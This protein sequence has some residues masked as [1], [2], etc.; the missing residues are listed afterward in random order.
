MAASP[1]TVNPSYVYWLKRTRLVQLSRFVS[2][3]LPFPAGR[4]YNVWAWMVYFLFIDLF[5]CGVREGQAKVVVLH[6]STNP[7]VREPLVRCALAGIWGR[8]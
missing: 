6:S 7:C 5:R 3:T 2:P 8:K 4:S 1:K